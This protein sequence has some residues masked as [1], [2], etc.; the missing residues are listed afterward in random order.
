M[1]KDSLKVKEVV[2]DAKMSYEPWLNCIRNAEKSSFITG[3]IRKV[4]YK[5][6]DGSEMLEEYSMDTGILMR[7]AWKKKTDVLCMKPADDNINNIM[8]EWNIELGELVPMPSAGDFMVK[9][10]NTAVSITRILQFR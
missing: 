2:I 10:S 1:I 4:H 7:R 9:E 3:K 8:Y 6:N 5:L